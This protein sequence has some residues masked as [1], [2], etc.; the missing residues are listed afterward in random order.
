MSDVGLDRAKDGTREASDMVIVRI[1]LL[2]EYL[3]PAFLSA[4]LS[5]LA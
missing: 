4:A 2:L 5:T 3:N 1:H